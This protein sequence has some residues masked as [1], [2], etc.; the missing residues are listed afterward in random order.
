MLFAKRSLAIWLAL[1]IL[2]I[3]VGPAL[4]SWGSFTSMGS[5]TVNADVSCAPTSGGKA[6]CAATGMSNTLLVNEYSGSA[7]SGWTKLAGAVTSA[8][9]CASDGNAHVVCA[10]R[11]TSGGL[12]ATIFNGT[13][14]S[15]EVKVKATLSSGP[16]CASLGGGRVLC[17]AR[18]STGG[19]ASTVF[20]GS[21]WSTFVN[22]T[23][24]S[25]SAP[26]CA[27]DDAGRVIC[28]M[29]DDTSSTI[30]TAT[31]T[32]PFAMENKTNSPASTKDANSR[33]DTTIQAAAKLA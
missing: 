28:A 18:S 15:T 2:L 22:Q 11:G 25:T 32:S 29:I 3:Q 9:S 19:L 13:A 12:S 16:S 7:W 5:T 1:P 17:A 26:N 14:W 20:N 10:A 8:P 23:A 24:N 30:V 4:A 21:T 27:S 31:K 6:V 33:S